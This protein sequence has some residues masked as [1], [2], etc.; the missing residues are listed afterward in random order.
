LERGQ[1]GLKTLDLPQVA[2]APG[3]LSN[4]HQL[5]GTTRTR[6][7]HACPQRSVAIQRTPR[8]FRTMSNL[9]KRGLPALAQQSIDCL[10]HALLNGTLIRLLDRSE[11]G[12]RIHISPSFHEQVFYFCLL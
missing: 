7:A 1:I 12:R 3:R 10:L 11:I 5:I 2:R 8:H 4:C 9:V 6:F